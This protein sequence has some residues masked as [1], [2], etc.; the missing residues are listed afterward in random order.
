M[1]YSEILK[2]RYMWRTHTKRDQLPKLK[3]I[4]VL[5]KPGILEI[6]E[7]HLFWMTDRNLVDAVSNKYE[8][9]YCINS[10]L[11]KTMTWITKRIFNTI[12]I[13]N[14][15][16]IGVYL[17]IATSMLNKLVDDG[18]IDKDTNIYY[19]DNLVRN[20]YTLISELN[21]EDLPF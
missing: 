1:S 14:Y 9:E 3:D 17:R 10:E 11:R 6:G 18:V 12:G 19:H 4:I 7:P 13:D 15:L 5:L 21:T 20:V 8:Y 2:Q 16:S